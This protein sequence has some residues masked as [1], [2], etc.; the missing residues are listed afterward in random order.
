PSFLVR[1][2]FDEI[3]RARAKFDTYGS[4]KLEVML[5]PLSR[6]LASMERG[7]F[8]TSLDDDVVSSCEIS[9]R[10]GSNDLI[11]A[12]VI[13]GARKATLVPNA[14]GDWALDRP[15]ADAPTPVFALRLRLPLGL[16]RSGERLEWS[17]GALSAVISHEEGLGELKSFALAP[18]MCA[19]P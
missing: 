3:H 4:Q 15:L 2:Y 16:E 10:A 6:D 14:N 18:R 7:H 12:R 11:R 13:V 19:G 9:R 17:Q 1:T 8:D 5:T